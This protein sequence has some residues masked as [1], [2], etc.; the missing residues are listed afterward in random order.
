MAQRK[1]HWISQTQFLFQGEKNDDHDFIPPSQP[2]DAELQ[3]PQHRP[4]DD[5]Q[6]IS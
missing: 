5:T 6:S 2:P 3:A 1:S 4:P